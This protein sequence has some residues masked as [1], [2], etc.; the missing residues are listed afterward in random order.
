VTSVIDPGL[1][2]DRATGPT[3]RRSRCPRPSSSQTAWAVSR[4]SDHAVWVW[5]VS[6]LKAKVQLV[7][8]PAH[9]LVDAERQRETTWAPTLVFASIGVLAAE[10]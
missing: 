9:A 3:G 10:E 2:R 1:R 4:A 8:H 7:R 5:P 6:G